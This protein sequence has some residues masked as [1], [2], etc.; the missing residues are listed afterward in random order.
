MPSVE[1]K[2]QDSNLIFG[3]IA[4][5]VRLE[6]SHLNHHSRMAAT[7]A[8]SAPAVRDFRRRLLCWYDRNRR[9]LP[10]RG[11]TNAYHVWVSEIMLQQTRVT[12]VEKRYCRFLRR[13]PTLRSLASARVAEVLAEWSGLGYYRRAR[14]LHQAARILWRAGGQLPQSALEWERLPGIGRYTA[15]AIA[16]IAGN[17]PVAT[18]DGN[19]ER[20]L[21][22]I[23]HGALPSPGGGPVSSKNDLW[24]RAQELLN[25][26]RPG[27]FNQAMMEL[28]ATVCAPLHPQCAGCP[29]AKHC[30]WNLR[31]AKSKSPQTVIRSRTE[32]SFGKQSGPQKNPR[33]KVTLGYDLLL[34]APGP[35]NGGRASD[36]LR[37]DSPVR[38]VYLVQR[39]RDAALMPS[40]WELPPAPMR[41]ENSAS[42][43]T[44]ASVQAMWLRHSITSTDYRVFVRTARIALPALPPTVKPRKPTRSPSSPQRERWIKVSRLPDLPLT[45]LA[46]KIL[47]RASLL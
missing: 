14:A 9:T 16:S 42:A 11:E 24:R 10:W 35:Q 28:G 21:M 43:A 25:R 2:L 30:G 39:P 31:V 13:F 5:H 32:F 6:S 19:V 15:A 18:V 46:R 40:M 27:D 29:V 37:D 44:S 4:V 34:L 23:F 47:R 26:R 3:R 7:T 17:Q 38:A 8:A 22:R 41:A 12:V 33:R 20:V 1:A 36:S 45:G